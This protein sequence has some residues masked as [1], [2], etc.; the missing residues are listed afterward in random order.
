MTTSAPRGEVFKT[1]PTWQGLIATNVPLLEIHKGAG[2]L[3]SIS[4]VASSFVCS[5]HGNSE[6]SCSHRTT[7]ATS[8]CVQ[9]FAFAIAKFPVATVTNCWASISYRSV[10][11][12]VGYERASSVLLRSYC[13]ATC[14]D[15]KRVPITDVILTSTSILFLTALNKPGRLS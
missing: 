2:T 4:S 10:S 14:L 3:A 1:A 9:R 5:F 13:V 7:K 15:P 11:H 12:V 8:T 6:M